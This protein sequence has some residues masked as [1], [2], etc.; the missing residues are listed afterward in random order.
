MQTVVGL[1]RTERPTQRATHDLIV[2]GAA[3]ENIQVLFGE[4]PVLPALEAA[5]V[6]DEDAILYEQAVRRGCVLV[7]A[8]VPDEIAER[9]VQIMDDCGAQDPEELLTD[10]EP[11]PVQWA[12]PAAE[13]RRRE[14]GGVRVHQRLT[15]RRHEEAI[16]L[17]EEQIEVERRQA[18]R[19]PTQAELAAFENATLEFN[20]YA[21]ELVITK[22]PRVIEEVVLRKNA[23]DR[24]EIV[25][26]MLKKSNIAVER[27]ESEERVG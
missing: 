20:E 13:L 10:P 17:A 27:F 7:T 18:D 19:E 14:D 1:F 23:R 4:S 25:S 16:T 22:R 3:P 5:G 2:S 21:E 8:T 9:A 12:E 6:P 24:R 15:E 26:E 11:P